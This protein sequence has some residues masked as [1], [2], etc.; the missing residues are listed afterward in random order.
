MSSSPRVEEYEMITVHDEGGVH[1]A[2]L[3]DDLPGD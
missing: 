2:R 3:L 1:P